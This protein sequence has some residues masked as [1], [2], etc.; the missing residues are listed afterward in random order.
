MPSAADI[1]SYSNI[2][3]ALDDLMSDMG[4]MS[5]DLFTKHVH[6]QNLSILYIMQNIFN[7][8]KNQLHSTM[9]KPTKQSSGDTP[10]MTN[11]TEK[12]KNTQRS[13]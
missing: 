10:G 5:S 6:H 7:N 8:A 12:T 1:H 11:V 2:L 3:L 9:Q 13:I 4:A